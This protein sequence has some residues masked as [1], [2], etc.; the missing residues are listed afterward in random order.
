MKAMVL[1]SNAGIETS[2][3]QWMDVASPEPMPDELRIKVSCCGIC[4]TDL[5]IIEGEL[6]LKKF[7]LIPGHQIV[8][9]V[10]KIG[11]G[12]R[13]FKVGSRIGIAWLR[14]T[15]GS[16]EF[17]KTGKE[18]LCPFSEYTGYQ[19]NGGY[20][21]YAI[22]NENYAYEIPSLYKDEEAVPLLCAGIV[23]YR[24]LQRSLLPSGGSLAIY[25][26]G[27]SA[28]MIMQIALHRACRVLVVTRGEKHRELARQMGAYW[29]GENAS[30]LPE[31]VDSAIV[32]APAGEIVPEALMHLKRGGTV[33]LAGIHM[34]EIP[35]L[36]YSQHLFYERNIHSVTA[37]TREDGINFLKEAAEIPIRP[38][39]K[40]YS[41]KDASLALQDLKND[42]ISGTGVL[43]I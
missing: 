33:S 10:D 22:I 34:S 43:V 29:V 26:F 8:G 24:A 5:H 27:S 7:P 12:C 13:R 42:R 28:H 9:I 35:Q 17:C 40:I 36:D 20:A 3:L 1:Q 39:I 37:N 6:P 18:N 4:R 41:L 2:P 21:E 19:V 30:D 31:K 23:G 11:S 14:S 32:F 38:H 16:C 15:C 25:G